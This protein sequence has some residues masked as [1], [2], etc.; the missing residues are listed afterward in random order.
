MALSAADLVASTDHARR[1]R[2]R[3]LLLA[4]R[5]TAAGEFPS[6]LERH[7]P[8]QETPGEVLPAPQRHG[9]LEILLLLDLV[10]AHAVGVLAPLRK[11]APEGLAVPES[12]R[13][14]LHD[15]SAPAPT[16]QRALERVAFP[17]RDGDHP[18]LHRRPRAARSARS[19]AVCRTQTRNAAAV[20]LK[21]SYPPSP[22]TAASSSAKPYP[23]RGSSS[24]HP[25][26]YLRA[27]WD[28]RSCT[29]SSATRRRTTSRSLAN[30][31]TGVEP[32]V[33][34]R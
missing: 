6:P 2:A 31:R 23:Y 13:V 17:E 21:S 15:V 22:A 16:R 32:A 7:L 8:S 25:A 14:Q 28:A 9:A 33:P 19:A 11:S 5:E 3:R 18:V 26:P 10:L 1:I 29:Y 30:A 34:G 27:A 24:Y 4:R 12:K 20:N